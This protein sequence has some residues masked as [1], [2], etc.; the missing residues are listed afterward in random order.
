VPVIFG[1]LTETIEQAIERAG[2]KAGNKAYD[3]AL[4]AIEMVNLQ[5]EC[6]QHRF[7]VLTKRPER[8]AELAG[9][10]CPSPNVWLGVSVENAKY[11]SR[12]EHLRRVPAKVR[13]LSIE[14]LLGPVG[15]LKLEGIHWVIVGGESGHGARPMDAEWVRDV[16]EQCRA[17]R[18]PFFFKQWGGV[19]KSKNGRLL[20]D[21]TWDEM[22]RVASARI[23]G[24]AAIELPQVGR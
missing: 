18:V 7:Q 19:M 4:A 12:I 20:D 14:P 16:R 11:R 10:L 22:P 24:A 5:R 23:R 1:V 9:R 3:A 8:L 2:T 15:T 13:F 6:P 17:S 21:R